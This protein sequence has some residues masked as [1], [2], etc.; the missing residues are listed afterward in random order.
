M[1]I[2]HTTIRSAA[3]PRAHAAGEAS[4]RRW[5]TLSGMEQADAISATLQSMKGAQQARLMQHVIGARLYGNASLAM[6]FG[7]KADRF[8]GAAPF[9]RDRIA[10]N[11]VQSAGDTV[12]ARVARDKPRPYFLT[13]GGDYRMQRKA[14]RLNK[15][16]EGVLY[17]ARAY[18]L[19]QEIFRDAFVLGD[20][21]I[22][23]F[24]SG[25]RVAFERVLSS[26]LWVDEA[27]AFY[28]FP[29]QMHRTKPVDRSVVRDLLYQ[30]AKD[31]RFNRKGLEDREE[32]LRTVEA[33]LVDDRLTGQRV[34]DLV[35]VRESWHLPDG[36]DATEDDPKGG[37]HVI[38]IANCV[39]LSEP[40]VK[41]CF[42]FARLP[43]SRRL[44]GY[45]SQG[46][47]EQLQNIQL[48]INKLLQL[49]QRSFHLGGTFKI[50]LEN[51]SKV[52]TEHLS[53]EIGAIV[54]YTGT[55]PQYVVPPMVQV[56]IFSH[57]VTLKQAAYEIV[58][59]SQ[60]SATSQKPAGLNSGKAL[61]EYDDIQSDRFAIVSQNYQQLFVDLAR[62]AVSVVE[63][64]TAGRRA[65]KVRAPSGRAVEEIDWRDVAL[66]EDA[67][68]LKCYPV[69]SLPRDP[70]GRLQTV[71]ELM[72]AGLLSPRTGKRL[73]DFPDL[74]AV[75]GLQNAAEE[76]LIATLDRI[77]DGD[78]MVVPEPYDD[79]NLARELGLEYYQRG[80]LQGLEEDRLEELRRFLDH[81][82]MLLAPAAVP[83]V[84]GVGEPQVPAMPPQPSDLVQNAP[85]ML[86]AAA[87]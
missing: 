8:A 29:R 71:Q 50:L 79:L 82:D 18:D 63:D 83:Q 43:W 69:S 9:L 86:P 55:P 61:R 75:E 19:G 85:G 62:L 35:E 41:P 37:A 54:K 47:A 25:G 44:Y 59:V 53:N 42:P 36:P 13:S 74:E 3:D 49:I 64:I 1:R 23:V 39:L 38:S 65:Y 78:G 11:V 77:V 26:E 80:K 46:G 56:E 67:Y 27:E 34:A 72:Q 68:V 21:V 76:Y 5:W 73:L 20:G 12:T 40:W 7:V 28:G 15:L 48:E 14:R 52:V 70:A 17:E 60:L 6:A 66:P 33:T 51:G 45:W 87:A 24:A 58:G 31:D 10:Y 32:A 30:W 84:S 16:V 57:L 4:T 22:H 2:D 81:V